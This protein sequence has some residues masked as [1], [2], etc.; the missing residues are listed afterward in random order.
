MYIMH[1]LPSIDSLNAP[2]SSVKRQSVPSTNLY[3]DK[4]FFNCSISSCLFACIQVMFHSLYLYV[5]CMLWLTCIYI[6]YVLCLIVYSL[7]FMFV[8]SCYGVYRGL[9]LFILYRGLWL[10]SKDKQKN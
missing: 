10:E 4:S 7:W 5:S 9:G 6:S 2:L 1:D 8:S 3:V